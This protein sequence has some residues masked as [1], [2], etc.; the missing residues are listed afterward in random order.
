MSNLR[1][2]WLSTGATQAALYRELRTL[3]GSLAISE[4]AYHRAM[5][6]KVEAEDRTQKQIHKAAESLKRKAFIERHGQ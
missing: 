1:E 4:S 2:A 5:S 6:G 3:F